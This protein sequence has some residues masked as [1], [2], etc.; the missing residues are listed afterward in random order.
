MT[1]DINEN[2]ELEP[3]SN[4]V[5]TLYN[6][7]LVAYFVHVL[8]NFMGTS[9]VLYSFLL[10]A[11]VSF[12]CVLYYDWKTSF[13]VL[14]LVCLVEG[15]GRIL[16]GYNPF[17]RIYFD[18]L[19]GL[20]IFRS[21]MNH[22]Q[23]FAF[24]F[25]PKFT[26]IALI[27]HFLWFI[28]ELFNPDSAG[29]FAS[30][31]TSKFYIFPFLLLFAHFLNPIQVSDIQFQRF[32][33]IFFLALGSLSL[34]CIFQKYQGS[35]YMNLLSSNYSTLFKKFQIFQDTYYRPWGTSFAPGG[36]S[37]F[38]YLTF[39]MIFLYGLTKTTQNKLRIRFEYVLLVVLFMIGAFVLFLSQVRSALIKMLLVMGLG[40][41]LG[42][43]KSKMIFRRVIMVLVSFLIAGAGTLTVINSLPELD[44]AFDL[45][46]SINRITE[47]G[48][49][50]KV[51]GARS[52]ASFIWKMMKERVSMPFGYGLGMTTGFLPEFDQKRQERK[53]DT[54]LHYYWNF[55]NL[56]MFFTLELG[57]GAIFIILAY[58]STPYY[59]FS[60][61]LYSLKHLSRQ[62]Y[63]IISISL[64]QT[65]VIIAGNWG[66]AGLVYNPE[67]FFLI[68]WIGLGFQTFYTS[69]HKPV[70]DDDNLGKIEL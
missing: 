70:E 36:F 29:V 20:A 45:Q 42:F 11:F 33:K 7:F 68:F 19:T 44:S 23:I 65:F 57:I 62:Q 48:N 47:L 8:L 40:L 67:S 34:L 4:K 28:L 30:I 53:L 66:A 14:C 16:L 55:D 50:E 32:L 17:F 59:L 25:L 54:P 37:I 2:I 24:K 63:L 10:L 12:L 15:Q 9:L 26:A 6:I 38:Y 3:K 21:A 35:S 49:E 58:L 43:L 56:L 39:G 27:L 46:V 61:M 13:Q 41:G 60:M 52:D 69:F 22:K 5:S 64:A 18:L 1:T 51:S 31:A